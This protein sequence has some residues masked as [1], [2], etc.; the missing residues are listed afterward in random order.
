MYRDSKNFRYL[1]FLEGVLKDI[2]RINKLFELADA[3]VVHLGADLIDF[4]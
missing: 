3:D 4:Y 1:V 2:S